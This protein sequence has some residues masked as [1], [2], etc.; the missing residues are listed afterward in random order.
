MKRLAKSGRRNNQRLPGEIEEMPPHGK[1]PIT[2][3]IIMNNTN[4][5]KGGRAVGR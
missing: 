1:S 3:P 4:P 5:R 2:S